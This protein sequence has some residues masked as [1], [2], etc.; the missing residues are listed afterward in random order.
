[1]AR[2]TKR[3]S[4]GLDQRPLI[5][6]PTNANFRILINVG[7]ADH[8]PIHRSLIV[9][10]PKKIQVLKF[11]LCEAWVQSLAREYSVKDGFGIFSL[12]FEVCFHES[13]R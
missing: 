12:A 7:C 10:P 9:Y 8:L 2:R 13:W 5:R 3:L 6:L 4:T 1:M 11:N